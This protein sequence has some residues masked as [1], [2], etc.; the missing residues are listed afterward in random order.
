MPLRWSDRLGG[1]QVR[2]HIRSDHRN[3][4]S[5]GS[6]A[7][8]PRPPHFDRH[9]INIKHGRRRNG[10]QADVISF[11]VAV[12]DRETVVSNYSGAPADSAQA[13]DCLSVFLGNVFALIEFDELFT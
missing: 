10:A 11:L 5:R 6:L 3:G 13:K 8:A 2:G 4:M 12:F 1:K 9:A 7:F